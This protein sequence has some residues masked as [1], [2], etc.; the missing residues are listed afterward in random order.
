VSH[1]TTV[2]TLVRSAILTDAIVFVLPLLIYAAQWLRENI[3]FD[4]EDAKDRER[5]LA[6]EAYYNKG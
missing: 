6:L 1:L 4:D 2:S 3:G 5:V